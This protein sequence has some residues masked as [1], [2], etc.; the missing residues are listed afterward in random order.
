M[1]GIV[2]RS[3]LQ[4]NFHYLTFYQRKKFEDQYNVM[5]MI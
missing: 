1:D 4:I 2:A 5:V 3:F